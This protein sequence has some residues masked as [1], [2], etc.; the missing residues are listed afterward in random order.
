MQSNQTFFSSLALLW[1]HTI[2]RPF[3]GLDGSN[4]KSGADA[5]QRILEAAK[6]KFG[7]AALFLF[8]QGRVE[9]LKVLA[10]RKCSFSINVAMLWYNF[11]RSIIKDEEITYQSSYKKDCSGKG[12][13]GW[14]LGSASCF[15]LSGFYDF[16]CAMKRGDQARVGHPK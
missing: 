3:F 1:F 13:V 11:D 14:G 7:D 2:V 12:Y 9:R 16:F 15:C 5:A 4:T 10:S 6:P 8:F